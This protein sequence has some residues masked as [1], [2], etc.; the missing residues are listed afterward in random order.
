MRSDAPPLMPVFRSR[1]QADL[2]TLLFLHPDLDHTVTDLAARLRI[3]LTTA[4]RELQRLEASGLV[5]GRPV[6]RSRLLR[7]NAGHHAFAPLA[8]LLLVTFGPHVVIAE[9]FADLPRAKTVVIYGSWAAR[10]EGVAGPAPGDIDVLVIGSPNRA[11][12]YAAAER[13]EARLGITV[14]PTVRSAGHW[15]DIDDPLVASIRANP[16]LDVTPDVVVDKPAHDAPATGT[17]PR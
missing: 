4:H 8:Q 15:A 9:E 16:Y 12:V 11:A 7:A 10:Y 2:L 5:E 3:P 13:A 14:N 6:G 17:V 1:H